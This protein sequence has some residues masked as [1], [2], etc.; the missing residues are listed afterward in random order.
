MGKAVKIKIY[1]MMVKS[2]VVFGSEIWA[3]AEMGMK[4]LGTGER[5]ILRTRGLA[6][7]QGIW[8]KRTDQQ[9]RELRRNL[10]LVADIKKKKL[11]WNGHVVRMDQGWT[12]KKI[13]ENKLEDSRRMR[14]P[15]LRWLEN[16]QKDLREIKFKIWQQKALDREELAFV[17]KETKAPR[18]PQTQGACK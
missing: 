8:R 4:R 5:K 7:E 2:A 6:V 13:F 9:L 18:R 17:I 14:R 11:E 15:R 1:K 10:D 12:L 16:V 3:V